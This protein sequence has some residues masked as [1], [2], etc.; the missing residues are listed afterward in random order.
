MNPKSPR[1]NARDVD[2]S[3]PPERR[4][5]TGDVLPTRTRTLRLAADM[6]KAYPK[7]PVHTI[8]VSAL[9]L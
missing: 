8:R 5:A 9:F 6:T 1:R 2:P 3:V 4:E 7:R